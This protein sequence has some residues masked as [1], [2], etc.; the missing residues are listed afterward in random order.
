MRRFSLR[1]TGALMSRASEFP[2]P[3]LPMLPAALGAA[4]DWRSGVPAGLARRRW[5]G[6]AP[7]PRGVRWNPDRQ[8][9]T[10]RVTLGSHDVNEQASLVVAAASARRRAREARRPVGGFGRT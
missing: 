5:S 4:A 10:C 7:P 8:G 3:N 9:G 2:L 6:C 1:V